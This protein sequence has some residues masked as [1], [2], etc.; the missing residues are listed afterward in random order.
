M[1]K[2][3]FNLEKSL[4]I[5]I[6]RVVDYPPCLLN[7]FKLVFYF[8]IGTDH[9]LP[10]YKKIKIL[11]AQET[12]DHLINSG[13]SF[14]R[15]GTGE[16]QI[17]MGMG[18]YGTVSA[19]KAETGLVKRMNDLFKQKKVLIGVGKRFLLSTDEELSQI[20][21]LNMFFR[22]RVYLHSV[23]KK[24]T[25]YG[26]AFAFRENFDIEKL[27]DFFSK[28]K[29]IIASRQNPNINT[30]VSFFPQTHFIECP[31]LNAYSEYNQT[32][33]KIYGEIKNNNWEKEKTLFLVALGPSAKP[34]VVDIDAVGFS[35]WDVGAIFEDFLFEKIKKHLHQKDN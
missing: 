30:F 28:K 31:P 35:A 6:R 15:F 10:F 24:N 19:Q 33:A 11:D 18:F 8:L 20:G 2:F 13:Q 4:E 5:M 32:L 34:L 16:S 25:V 9:F 23:L 12:I 17:A 14:V 1:K 22:N 7:Y 26:E 27:L 3:N 29:L 21:K